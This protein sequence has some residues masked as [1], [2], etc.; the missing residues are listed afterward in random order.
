MLSF[1]AMNAEELKSLIHSGQPHL[2]LDVLPE[3]VHAAR[4]IPGSANACVYEMA[5]LDQVMNLAPE[6]S[7]LIVVYGAGEDS[8]D[9]SVAFE[10]LKSAG[11]GNVMVFTDGIG[12]W[13][14]AGFPVEGY[15]RL[16]EEPPADGPFRV[17]VADS[18]IRWTGRN[19]FNHHNGT[20]RISSGEILMS[21]GKMVSARFD[22]DLQSILCEDIADESMSALLIRHL[23]DADFF[24]VD[25]HPTATFEA[26]E[27]VA[28]K[29]STPGSPNYLL[30]GNLTLRGI[31]KPIEF[32][33]VIATADGKRI[34]G[35]G[36]LE[37]DRT[38]F[39]SI[40]GSGRF[41]KFLGKHV[42]NDMIHLHVKIHADSVTED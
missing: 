14:K 18:I 12:S 9:S 37:V 33:V 15:G 20:V 16:P 10:K 25:Q 5:F 42:V 30:R 36:Q 24:Q 28:M 2:L 23:Q 4:H 38:E 29:A 21:D 3:E 19:L 8:Q 22:I 13:K 35:Q 17:N 32:P 11:Y 39:G 7:G 34:T 40:Y 31:T 27:T 1:K 6:K 26:T 41:F